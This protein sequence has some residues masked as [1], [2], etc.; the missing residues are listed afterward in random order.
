MRMFVSVGCLVNNFKAEGIRGIRYI[1]IILQKKIK[2]LSS[3][4]DIRH[5]VF[6]GN[7]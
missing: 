6:T 2:R 4:V 3:E 5:I 1:D 7:N